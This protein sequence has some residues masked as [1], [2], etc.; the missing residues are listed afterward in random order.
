MTTRVVPPDHGERAQRPTEGERRPGRTGRRGP[1]QY[2]AV[3]S[4][5]RAA[6]ASRYAS[7][8]TAA[9]RRAEA[10]RPAEAEQ[11]AEQRRAGEPGDGQPVEAQ[12][13][14][15]PGDQTQERQAH[16]DRE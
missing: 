15:H 1:A 6:L 3:S 9:E 8:W 5:P 10:R 14:L 16:Q 12:L 2:A 4:A 7:A 13:A 11:H